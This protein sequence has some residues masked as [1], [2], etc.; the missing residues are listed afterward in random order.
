MLDSSFNIR[1]YCHYVRIKEYGLVFYTL[2]SCSRSLDG[3]WC[4]ATGDAASASRGTMS[5]PVY[6][7]TK[8]D[9]RFTDVLNHMGQFALVDVRR[10]L[11]PGIFRHFLCWSS[12]KSDITHHRT[13]CKHGK[14]CGLCFFP[15]TSSTFQVWQKNKRLFPISFPE[16]RCH[17][18][19]L[20]NSKLERNIIC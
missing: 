17:G 7:Q 2:N 19:K 20:E 18:I 16:A 11:V 1:F 3:P 4:I 12:S 6:K 8:M 10:L 15:F 13:R 14:Y 9:A 5:S